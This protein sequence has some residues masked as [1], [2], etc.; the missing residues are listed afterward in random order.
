MPW[1]EST[2][3]ER[4]QNY[5][6]E[7]RVEG[8]EISRMV[9]EMDLRGIAPRSGYVVQGAHIYA[10]VLGYHDV[11]ADKEQ[12]EAVH[13]QALEFLHFHYRATDN[14]LEEEEVLRVDFHGPRLHAVV[15]KPYGDSPEANSERVRKAV[16]VAAILTAVLDQASAAAGLSQARLRVGIDCGPSLVVN[17]GS[18]GDRDPLFLG[19]PANHAAKLAA[20]SLPGV[21]LTVRARN[22]LGDA[23]VAANIDRTPSRRRGL[24]IGEIETPLSEGQLRTASADVLREEM[25]FGRAQRLLEAARAYPSVEFKF[26]RHTPPLNSI[27]FEKLSP[28]NSI[29][30]GMLS[31][32]ADLNGFTKFVDERMGS[33]EDLRSAAQTLFVVRA[34]LTDV[35]RSDFEGKKVRLI[36]DCVQGICGEGSAFDD[37]PRAAVTTG[38]FCAAA[39]QSSF[40]LIQRMLPDA[41]NLGLVVGLDYGATP[42]TRLGL[43]GKLSVR[44]A[45]SQAVTN[46]EIV[47]ESL[48]E[49]DFVGLGEEA[50]QSAPKSIR[51]LFDEDRRRQMLRYPQLSMALRQ[52]EDVPTKHLATLA[53]PATILSSGDEPRHHAQC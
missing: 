12:T 35:L 19:S 27:E 6:D 3:T 23:F 15:T 7:S 24:S 14:I 39:M 37:D 16:E 51:E 2:A 9:R 31:L 30:M 36:G 43:R 42:V 18:R 34:E 10:Q 48:S 26:H 40:E 41:Q 45:S 22:A 17:N 28:A 46:A 8:F 4:I 53:A 44:V 25:I 38:V 49:H 13:R 29:R 52:A 5:L 20:G 47:Q 50:F 21:Y 33:L 11:L 32:F 1:N